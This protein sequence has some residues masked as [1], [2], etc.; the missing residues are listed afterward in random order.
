MFWEE[1]PDT[2]TVPS[3][4]SGFPLLLSIDS[5]AYFRNECQGFFRFPNAR[6]HLRPSGFIVFE[7]LETLW[8][9]KHEFL[10]WLL[11]RNNTKLCSVVF[12]P[13]FFKMPCICDLLYS[14][15][16]HCICELLFLKIIQYWV[17]RRTAKFVS[18]SVM[19][20]TADLKWFTYCFCHGRRKVSLPENNRGR[21]TLPRES[22]TE[23]YQI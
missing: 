22:S 13:F 11:Q 2:F 6:K 19:N 21:R 9:P 16:I 18:K 8:N 7:R 12:F 3:L 15:G 5:Q 20:L 4:L 17:S 1:A 10:K 14:V 23:F